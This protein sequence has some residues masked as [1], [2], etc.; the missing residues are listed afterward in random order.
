MLAGILVNMW[1]SGDALAELVSWSVKLPSWQRDALRRLVVSG[2]L[3]DGCLAELLAICCGEVGAPA[4]LP[5]NSTHIGTGSSAG[6]TV[7]LIAIRNPSGV[8]ALT[9]GQ[10]LTF[11]P[12]G[13]TIIY[14]ENGA[15]KSGYA[16]ILKNACRAKDRGDV[17]GDVRAGSG[18]AA[19]P[20]AEIELQV[21]G[22]T[23]TVAWQANVACDPELSLISVFDS[24]T[25]SVRVDQANEV[26]YTPAP[27]RLLA[28]LANASAALEDQIK[29][30]AAAIAAR[31]PAWVTKPQCAEGTGAMA[32]LRKLNPKTDV[33][34]LLQ[35]L[36]LKP[37]EEARRQKL[38]DD[39]RVD[40]ATLATTVNRRAAR[41][42]RALEVVT[43]A[44]EAAS[45]ARL[46]ALLAAA[47]HARSARAAA[48]GA[49]NLLFGTAT[50]HGIGGEAWRHLWEAARRF[51]ESTAYP[52]SRFPVVDD[53]AVCVLCVQQ[54]SASTGARL[55]TF[56]DFVRAD[57]QANAATAEA[58]RDRMFA[59]WR[60]L[61]P[62]V[63]VLPKI[64]TV[65]AEDCTAPDLAT[66]VR[67][68]LC[69]IR[70]ALRQFERTHV[71]PSLTMPSPAAAL[72]HA[73]DAAKA[74]FTKLQ[75]SEAAAHLS[76]LKQELLDLDGR[77]WLTSLKDDLV[78]EVARLSDAARLKT[79]LDTTNTRPLSLKSKDISQKLVTS[80]LRDAFAA[81]VSALGIPDLHV[82]LVDDGAK[83]GEQQFRLRLVSGAQIALSRVLSE[84]EFRMVAL[85]AFLAELRVVG[86]V[87]G[88]VF[89]DPVS[90]LDHRH[91]HAVAHRL[92]RE[93]RSRQVI[94]FTHDLF[95]LLLLQRAAKDGAIPAVHYQHI[96]RGALGERK[97]GIITA[98]LPVGALDTRHAIRM[99]QHRLARMAA[100]VGGSEAPWIEQAEALCDQLRK[101]WERALEQVIGAVL[102]RHAHQMRF[103]RIR[104]LAV[105]DGQ[106]VEE[107]LDGYGWCSRHMHAEAPAGPRPV[108]TPEDFER[109]FGQLL[110]WS[111]RLKDKQKAAKPG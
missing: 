61:W 59:E 25:A 28:D 39:L 44:E 56:E 2:S 68:F 83:K 82:E 26:F 85:A 21:D 106:D 98:D 50:I 107:A 93:A 57:T 37:S 30:K 70:W 80:V 77:A 94:V 86:D 79:A 8:N 18:P 14:G 27:M 87:C 110:N 111:E 32:A 43:Q 103:N 97:P 1:G 102:H 66:A 101:T 54:I 74:E 58:A 73:A 49:A 11:G 92:V 42:D 76:A 47:L 71:M 99:M 62:D 41:F 65:L 6:Q 23:R 109:R 78:T 89:D 22:N 33:D 46:N 35:Q 36:T 48:D 84:G 16:R 64:K 67:R 90:S 24:A 10:Q 13:L 19:T 52:S 96:F 38:A 51:S 5:C 81:E 105:L 29:S 53:G 69:S 104:E 100:D 34:A 91:R 60:K 75:S 20:S 4:A 72:R 12:S 88:I 3:T 45:A 9:G 63:T 17:L 7:S 31:Q 95:F 55:K 108:P 15:G 40:P